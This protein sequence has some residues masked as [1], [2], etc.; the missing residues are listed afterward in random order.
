MCPLGALRSETRER[1]ETVVVSALVDFLF[2]LGAD[3]KKDSKSLIAVFFILHLHNSY[4]L[5]CITPTAVLMQGQRQ[6]Q[7]DLK[8]PIYDLTFLQKTFVAVWLNALVCSEVKVI[9]E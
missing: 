7:H 5:I 6:G 1:T 8:S 9:V 2:F 4:Y 3:I